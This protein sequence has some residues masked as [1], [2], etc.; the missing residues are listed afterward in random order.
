MFTLV[1]VVYNDERVS[2]GL[3]FID[4]HGL[5]ES[6]MEH[7]VR[8]CDINSTNY[9]VQGILETN[10]SFSG[11]Q[12]VNVYTQK[13]PRSLDINVVEEITGMRDLIHVLPHECKM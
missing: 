9:T 10:A 12:N 13:A 6:P 4:L 1:V 2:N 7:T 8:A 3:L 5:P 11:N